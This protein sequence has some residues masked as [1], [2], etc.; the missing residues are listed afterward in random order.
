MSARG[1]R[2]GRRCWLPLQDWVL[3][4]TSSEQQAAC[5]AGKPS[6]PSVR[7]SRDRRVQHYGDSTGTVVT[8]LEPSG[9]RR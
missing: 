4:E 5:I 8:S 3:V 2:V 9:G 7:A 1:K 6:S